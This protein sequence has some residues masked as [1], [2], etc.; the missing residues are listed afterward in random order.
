MLIIA[1]VNVDFGCGFL[2]ESEWVFISFGW[3][4]YL[5]ADNCNRF[6][7]RDGFYVI[8]AFFESFIADFLYIFFYCDDLH[9]RA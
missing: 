1:Y 2:N 9:G 3:Q 7:F 6:L 5:H 4:I 8:F